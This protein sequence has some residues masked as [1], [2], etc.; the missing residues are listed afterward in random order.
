MCSAL[1]SM[2]KMVKLWKIECIF[3]TKLP[4]NFG[5]KQSSM[6]AENLITEWKGVDRSCSEKFVVENS[7]HDLLPFFFANSPTQ[8]LLSATPVETATMFAKKEQ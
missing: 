7:G 1:K 8:R 5:R 2:K 6:W 3:S 4:Y